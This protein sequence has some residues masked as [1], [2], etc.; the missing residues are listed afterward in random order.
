MIKIEDETDF[1]DKQI[2]VA[3]DL[4]KS[5]LENCNIKKYLSTEFIYSMNGYG[6]FLPRITIFSLNNF[7]L[8]ICGIFINNCINFDQVQG[9]LYL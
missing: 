9:T 5:I 7:K 1:R 2:V 8:L 6:F 3:E 4:L